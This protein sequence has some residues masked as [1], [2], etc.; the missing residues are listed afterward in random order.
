MTA[1]F[2]VQHAAGTAAGGAARA[3]CGRRCGGTWARGP[4]PPPAPWPTCCWPPGGLF[5]ST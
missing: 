4:R 3:R 1:I 2:Q 5:K